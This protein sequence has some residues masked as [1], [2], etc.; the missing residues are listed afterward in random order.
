M[1]VGL[2]KGL[3]SSPD[4]LH[5]RGEK[6]AERGTLKENSGLTA[7]LSEMFLDISGWIRWRCPDRSCGEN[8]WVLFCSREIRDKNC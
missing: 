7:G 1:P 2:A 5:W 8:L 4:N 6:F 3:Q